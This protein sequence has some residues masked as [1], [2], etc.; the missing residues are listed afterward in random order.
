HRRDG[1]GDPGD[2]IPR[3]RRPA[4]DDAADLFADR[5]VR[6]IAQHQIGS[7]RQTLF[8]F[9]GKTCA[10]G[11]LHS[12]L[13][14]SSGVKFPVQG[15]FAGAVS[16]RAPAERVKPV[17]SVRFFLL[18]VRP[19]RLKLRVRVAESRQIRSARLDVQ[20]AEQFVI[21]RLRLPLRHAAVRV[22]D[23]AEDDGVGRAGLRAGR[24]D[25]AVLNPP[26][27]ALLP[28]RRLDF[29]LR[30]LDALHAVAAFLHHAAHADGDFGVVD[31]LL[32]FVVGVLEILV[33][34]GKVEAAHLVGAVVRAVPRADAAVIGHRVE[35]LLAVNRRGDRADVFAGRLLAVDTGDRLVDCL[36]AVLV[37]FRTGQEI[38]RAGAELS[39]RD[40]G[41]VAIQPNPVHLAPAPD[42]LLADDGDVVF[43]LAGHHAGVAADA[44]I[45]VNRHAP[46]RPGLEFQHRLVKVGLG[47]NLYP[48]GSEVRFLSE[49]IQGAFAHDFAPFHAPVVLRHT[50]RIPAP[51]LLHC[52][53]HAEFGRVR[54]PQQVSIATATRNRPEFAAEERCEGRA[55]RVRVGVLAAPANPAYL[56]ATITERD[57]NRIVG[58]TRH[59]PDGDFKLATAISQLHHVFTTDLE[60]SR[61]GDAHHRRVVP[62]QLGHW[63]GRF[64]EPAVIG[65]AAVVEARVLDEVDLDVI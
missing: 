49:L 7:G 35:A 58:V 27:L 5:F 39:Y 16:L 21:A 63:V 50:Q 42:L 45:E 54:S 25:G 41:E 56:R 55:N 17:L 64:L 46:L 40:A 33:P 61:R 1:A 43:R 60:P 23:V 44:R 32:N 3:L 15:L 57:G 37:E 51:G 18:A 34:V 8:L 62:G 48:F 22:A 4:F 52:Y 38:F 20:F 65:E 47:R 59:D 12:V 36:N 2:Q 24:G 30:V 31:H 29:D 53:A 19:R 13:S 11:F 28:R 10:N 14:E 9:E 26:F 6:L